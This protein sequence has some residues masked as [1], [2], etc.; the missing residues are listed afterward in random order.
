MSDTF[1]GLAHRSGARETLGQR[2]T[3]NGSGTRRA[4]MG[5]ASQST[6]DVFI[7]TG[8]EAGPVIRLCP[9]STDHIGRKRAKTRQDSA[10]P[11]LVQGCVQEAAACGAADAHAWNRPEQKPLAKWGYWVYN[12]DVAVDVDR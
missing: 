10:L 2:G 8:P 9:S 1:E 5:K 12:D 3:C 4:R 11:P 6:V 7:H